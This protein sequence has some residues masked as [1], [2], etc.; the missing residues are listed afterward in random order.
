MSLSMFCAVNLNISNL[1]TPG[2][3]KETKREAKE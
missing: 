2:G 3:K 1:I